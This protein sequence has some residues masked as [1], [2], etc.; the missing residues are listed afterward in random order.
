MSEEM[1]KIK[2]FRKQILVDLYNQCEQDQQHFFNRMYG[3]IDTI[4][5]EKIDWAIQQCEMTIEKNKIKKD[6]KL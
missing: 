5:D 1:Q 4:A 3:S 2:D 6:K